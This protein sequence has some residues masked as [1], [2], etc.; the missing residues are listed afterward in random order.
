MSKG[1]KQQAK[2]KYLFNKWR[3]F[4]GPEKGRRL[5]KGS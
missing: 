1:Y 3:I 2:M 5:K 4:E